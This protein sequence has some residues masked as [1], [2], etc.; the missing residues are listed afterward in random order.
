MLLQ[1]EPL[2]SLAARL[3]LLAQSI[4]LWFLYPF[5]QDVLGKVL[6]VS[7]FLFYVYTLFQT[8]FSIQK[9]TQLPGSNI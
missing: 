3:N 7:N 8:G 4:P 9:E 2:I 5:Q 1:L 6:V